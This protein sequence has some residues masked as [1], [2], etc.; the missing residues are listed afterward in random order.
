[1][2]VS[3]VKQRAGRVDRQI[4]REPRSRF[5]RI[6][7]AAE[8]RGHDGAAR[9]AAGGRD[10]DAAKEGLQRNLGREARAERM[11]RALIRFRA[12]V[13]EPDLFRESLLPPR[14]GKRWIWGAWFLV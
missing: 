9:F 12:D 6:H 3:D 14:R 5:R 4:Q 2:T 13:E 8:F 7:V 10:A 11:K 1:M